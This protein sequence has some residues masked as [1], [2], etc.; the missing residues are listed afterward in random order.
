VWKVD[1]ADSGEEDLVDEDALLNETTETLVAK[2]E[3]GPDSSGKKRACKNCTCGLAEQENNAEGRERALKAMTTDDK[4]KKA[5]GCGGCAKG[6]A[7]RCAGC[8]FLGMPAFEPGNEKIV[9]GITDD[10]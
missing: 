9:L 3:C 6:D 2:S 10:I 1:S 8:P 7:F 5:S 4:I